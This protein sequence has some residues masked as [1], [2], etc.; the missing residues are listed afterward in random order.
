MFFFLLTFVLFILKYV[1]RPDSFSGCFYCTTTKPKGGYYL[2]VEHFVLLWAHTIIKL[3]Q[4]CT[5]NKGLRSPWVFFLV[6]FQVNF[7]YV[8]R[9]CYN[10]DYGTSKS[11]GGEWS[12]CIGNVMRGV[13]L[14]QLYAI[15]Q[16][17]ML[18]C[19]V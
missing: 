15:P 6:R 13:R 10:N 4:V 1:Y 11:G 14:S 3:Q 12:G 18:Y 7:N 17:L 9:E 8:V 16:T 2:D 19:K 5:S